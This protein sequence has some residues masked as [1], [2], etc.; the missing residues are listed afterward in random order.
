MYHAD[1]RVGEIVDNLVQDPGRRNEIGVEN[2]NKLPFGLFKAS[3][4]GSCFETA[5][6]TAAHVINVVSSGGQA[7]GHLECFPTGLV[8]R[9]VKDLD[10]QAIAGIVDS[11]Y[12]LEQAF[13]H[14]KLVVKGKLNGDCRQSFKAVLGS[15]RSLMVLVEQMQYQVSVGTVN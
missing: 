7:P 5:A 2:E 15:D 10:L 14:V 11:A 9:I 13:Y 12:R 4:K 8:S 6:R 3:S 1:F